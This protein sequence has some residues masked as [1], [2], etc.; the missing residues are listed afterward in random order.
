M[1]QEKVS[2]E[3]RQKERNQEN[4]EIREMGTLDLNSRGGKHGIQLLTII[5]EI[6]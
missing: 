6:E 4:E 1:N 3:D 2:A 5:G